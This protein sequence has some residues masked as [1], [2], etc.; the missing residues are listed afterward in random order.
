[1]IM[2]MGPGSL[3]IELS[4]IETGQSRYNNSF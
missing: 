4:N 2:K 3:Y 1:M